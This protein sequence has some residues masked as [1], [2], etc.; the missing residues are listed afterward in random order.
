MSN[1]EGFPNVQFLH[2]TSHSKEQGILS[3]EAFS[4]LELMSSLSG[5]LW[6]SLQLA[7]RKVQVAIRTSTVESC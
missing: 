6:C 7:T 1:F 5:I 2:G 3:P 4:N